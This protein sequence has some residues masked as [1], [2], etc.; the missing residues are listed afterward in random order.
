VAENEISPDDECGVCST[1]RDQ[2]GDKLHV[3]TLTDQLI[4]VKEPPAPRQ[5]APQHREDKP[6]LEK[7]FATLVE[8]LAEKQVIDAKDVVRIFFGEG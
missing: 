1:K 2:H 8:I 7:P 4:P 6:Q 5:Q 3:F